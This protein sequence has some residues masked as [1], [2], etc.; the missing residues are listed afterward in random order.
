MMYLFHNIYGDADYLIE[1]APSGVE[2]VPFGWTE[3]AE[4][5]RNS[6]LAMMDVTVSFLPSVV[7]Q[8]PEKVM[9]AMCMVDGE[10]QPCEETVPEHWE[11]LRLDFVPEPKDWDTINRRINDLVSATKYYPS[12]D[13]NL[14]WD[15]DAQEWV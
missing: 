3:S 15:A 1:S 2:C 10:M 7:F 13:V 12:A 5:Y 8:M 14:T 11:E 4:Q 9:P 6:L